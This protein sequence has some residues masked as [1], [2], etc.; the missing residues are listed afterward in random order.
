MS[1]YEDEMDVDTSK[2]VQ[3]G[4]DNAAGKKRTVADLPVEAQD[5]LPWVEKYRPESLDEVSG[6]QDILATINRFVEA[7]RLPHLLLYGPPGTGKTSTV[8]ALARKIYGTK[9]MRQMVLELNASDDRGIDVVREQIKTF[10]STKQIF[11]MAPQSANASLAGFKLI[12]LDEADAMTSTAQMALRRIMERYTAN[13]RFC[14]IANYTHKLSPALLSRCTR[15][16]FSPL[17]EADIRSLVDTVI[18]KEDIK[19][20]PDAVD[21]LVTLSKGDMRRAL[22]VLQA[23]HASSKPLPMRDAPNAPAPEPEIITNATIYDCIAAPHPAD[24]QEIMSTIL[25]TSDVT[26]CLNTVNTL[27][28][29]KGLALADILSALADQLQQLEVPAQTRITWLEGLAEIEYRLS[30]GGSESI[31]TGGLVG[32]VRN[33]CELMGDKGVA[34]T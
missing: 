31:Q 19:I 2:D 23:C 27:K 33:G 16:R 32:V 8:L 12:I 13:T 34:M 20:Q 29:T 7:N 9:N 15:F 14:I 3:F 5:N 10:A 24:I 30:G 6:H 1:D 25:N 22:N 21:S 26:S 28:A 17:K 18:E 4:S 11:S